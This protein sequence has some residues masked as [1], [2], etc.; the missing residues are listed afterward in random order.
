MNPALP[1][2]DRLLEEAIQLSA[3]DL[4]F[5]PAERKIDIYLR[6][7]GRRQHHR[8]ISTSQFQL[9]LTY[10]KFSSGMDI[11]ESRKPQDGSITRHFPEFGSF[12]LRLST[13]PFASTESLAIRIL[14][15]EELLPA[16]KLFLFPNQLQILKRWAQ[17]KSGLPDYRSYWKRQINNFVCP[18]Q[19]PHH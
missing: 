10:F 14:P 19:V 12:S 18:D 2:I 13:L 15:Q 5:Y 4:H 3:T 8:T 7:L 11:G 16:E 17:H 1:I 6:I 9:I